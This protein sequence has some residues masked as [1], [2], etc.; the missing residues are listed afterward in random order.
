MALN[1]L[2]PRPP[3]PW[4]PLRSAGPPSAI[5][6]GLVASNFAAFR[7]ALP[8]AGRA[9]PDLGVSKSAADQAQRGFQLRSDGPLEHAHGSPSGGNGRP[10]LIESSSAKP[11]AGLRH[12]FRGRCSCLFST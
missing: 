4:L 5:G 11:G 7:T 8:V 2:R 12:L 10:S 3:P 6:S 1:G 9:G